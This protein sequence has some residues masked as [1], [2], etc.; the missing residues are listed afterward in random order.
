MP[1]TTP[2][3]PTTPPSEPAPREPAPTEPEPEGDGEPSA[4]D[5]QAS[6]EADRER[7]R[8]EHEEGAS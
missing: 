4:A 3:E 6:Y 2:P 5:K 7:L 8:R 1:E